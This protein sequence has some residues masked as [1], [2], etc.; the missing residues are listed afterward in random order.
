ME[1]VGKIF[2]TFKGLGCIEGARKA[3][4]PIK[5]E[6]KKRPYKDALKEYGEKIRKE[7]NYNRMAKNKRKRRVN[8]PSIQTNRSPS[9]K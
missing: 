5:L 9:R 6:A 3:V 1:L 4:G 2:K 7:K 8:Y